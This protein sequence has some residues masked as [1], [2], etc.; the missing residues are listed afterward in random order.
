M[1]VCV[2][3]GGGV[4]VLPKPPILDSFETQEQRNKNLTKNLKI[5]IYGCSAGQSVP[6]D[7]FVARLIVFST[8]SYI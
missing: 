1:S 5:V 7:K 3:R 4:T 6:D 8:L 2:C